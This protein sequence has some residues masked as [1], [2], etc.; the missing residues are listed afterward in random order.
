MEASLRAVRKNGP[1]GDFLRA[2]R[3]LVDPRDVGIGDTQRRRV[4]GLRRDELAQL[5]NISV[6]YY[7]RLEQGKHA[8]AS[9]S[10][11]DSL[12]TALRLPPAER[13]YLH[14]LAGVERVGRATRD[15][16]VR[17]ETIRLLDALGTAPAFVLGPNMDILATN[18]AAGSLYPDDRGNAIQWLLGARATRLFGEDRTEIATELIGMLRLHAGRKPTHP[19]IQRVVG[20]LTSSSALFRKVWAEHAVSI[21]GRRLERGPRRESGTA[22]T[23]AVKLAE[24][25]TVLVFIPR[26]QSL[27]AVQ[28]P[29]SAD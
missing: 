7:T 9:R 14:R 16:E 12:A 10:V 19:G 29:P 20:E 1:L 28:F 27:A 15:V 4:I 18:A 23:L 5:A 26:S 3:A 8:A 13:A 11:L 21:G 22:E 17:P 24:D 6:H 25:Q 2:R